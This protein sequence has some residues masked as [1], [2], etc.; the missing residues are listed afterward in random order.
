[1][2]FPTMFN[3]AVHKDALGRRM[4]GTIQGQKE[5][6]SLVLLDLLTIGK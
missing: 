2:S 3:L 5:D 4:F 6:G 1:M